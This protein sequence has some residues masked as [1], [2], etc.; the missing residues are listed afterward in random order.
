MKKPLAIAAGINILFFGWMMVPKTTTKD[1]DESMKWQAKPASVR[2]IEERDKDRKSKLRT[3]ASS[4]NIAH[5]KVMELSSD[6]RALFLG[7]VV[8]SVGD[9][10]TGRTGFS[11][12]WTRRTTR[13]SGASA[14]RMER[15][16]KFQSK[17]M[18]Q[19]APR[20]WIVL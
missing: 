1:R 19:E 10:C 6:L 14:V 13:H 17:R 3:T 18:P 11:W 12:A 8:D 2:T 20:S 9:P 15:A 7:R 4:G 16:T 5:D